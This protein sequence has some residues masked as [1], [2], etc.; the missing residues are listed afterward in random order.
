MPEK[1]DKKPKSGGPGDPL[2][3]WGEKKEKEAIK[4]DEVISAFQ[5]GKEIKVTALKGHQ[6]LGENWPGLFI[7]NGGEQGEVIGAKQETGETD[8]GGSG[9]VNWLCIKW[10]YTSGGD[11]D[12]LE[13]W[14]SDNVGRSKLYDVGGDGVFDFDGDW[15][16]HFDFKISEASKLDDRRQPDLPVI[17]NKQK[18][19]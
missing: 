16:E 15:E 18:K 14:Y 17:F 11:V 12:I 4:V 1:F 9:I 10:Y 8:N 2:D 13:T 5:E 6:V 7:I 19:S 3:K